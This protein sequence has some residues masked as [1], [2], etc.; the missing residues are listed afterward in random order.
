MDLRHAGV[1]TSLDPLLKANKFEGDIAGLNVGNIHQY[2]ND[3]N[4]FGRNAIRDTWRRWP[5]GEIPVSRLR[6]YAYLGLMNDPLRFLQYVISTR[7]GSYSKQII[8]KAMDEYH[9][10]TCIRFIPRDE[11]LHRDYIYIFPDDG[12]YSLVGRTGGR[13]P[14]S[15][16]AGCIQVSAIAFQGQR[17]QVLQQSVYISDRHRPTRADACHWLLP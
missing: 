15:L 5:N 14:V 16:D 10:K 1:D 9:K 4:S 7:Y 3:S 12:C 8:A 17:P 2:I 11:N 6:P 13:Q